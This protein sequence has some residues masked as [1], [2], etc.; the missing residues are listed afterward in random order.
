MNSP[1]YLYGSGYTKIKIHATL[2]N[3]KLAITIIVHYH[4]LSQQTPLHIA[5]GEGHDYTVKYLVGKGA[6]INIKDMNGV[7]MTILLMIL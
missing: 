4:S 1:H 2:S 5:A 3:R 7:C 6:V